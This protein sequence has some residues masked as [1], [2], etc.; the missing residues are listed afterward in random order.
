VV[1]KKLKL[2]MDKES[3]K[4][5]MANQKSQADLKCEKSTQE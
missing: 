3:G 1:V 2:P 4:E 5:I